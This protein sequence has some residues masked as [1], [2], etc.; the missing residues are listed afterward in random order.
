MDNQD[1]WSHIK[2]CK[3]QVTITC[4]FTCDFA[5]ETSFKFGN[6]VISPAFR[7]SYIK[8]SRNTTAQQ[9]WLC[10]LQSNSHSA[11][12][13]VCHSNQNKHFVESNILICQNRRCTLT[14]GHRLFVR[15]CFWSRNYNWILIISKL[16]CSMENKWPLISLRLI[17]PIIWY[18]NL[19]ILIVYI[20][21]QSSSH[22]TSAARWR[23]H[24]NR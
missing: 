12:V 10:A 24:S 8:R 6:S 14:S 4:P 22:R 21:G 20:A 16:I 15:C 1:R 18:R 19:W 23:S 17:S 13:C 9:L 5:C 11:L 7:V 3:I 2:A